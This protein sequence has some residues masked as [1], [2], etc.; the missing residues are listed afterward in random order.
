MYLYMGTWTLRV[1][2]IG[3]IKESMR[4]N[5]L[6][7]P[8]AETLNQSPEAFKTSP[9]AARAALRVHAQASLFGCV[10]GFAAWGAFR[11]VWAMC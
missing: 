2:Q 9:L 7:C 5:L 8:K 3:G 11:V 1:F 4:T 6:E 10:S